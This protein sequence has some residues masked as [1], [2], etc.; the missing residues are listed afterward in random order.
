M[1]ELNHHIVYYLELV[2]LFVYLLWAVKKAQLTVCLTNH[3][4]NAC[5]GVFL[6]SALVLGE[7]SASRPCRSTTR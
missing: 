5:E 6:T 7:W 3:A 2:G 4:M 1:Y